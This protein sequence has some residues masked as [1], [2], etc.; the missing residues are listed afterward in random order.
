MYEEQTFDTIISRELERLNN[1]GIDI[2]EGSLIYNAL[3]PSTWELQ[4]I[5]IALDFILTCLYADTANRPYLIR[6]AAERGIIPYPATAAI[7]QGEFNCNIPLGS[8]FSLDDTNWI[9]IE[10]INNTI[11][12]MRCEQLGIIG[13]KKTGELKALEYIENLEYA[14]ITDL[15]IP[16]EEE[17]ETEHLRKRYF[18][19]LTSQAFGGNIADY[20]AKVNSIVGVGGVKVYPCWDGGGTVKL[21]IINSKYEVSSDALINTVQ[22]IVDPLTNSGKGYGIAPIGHQVTIVSVTAQPIDLQIQL[23]Y[24]SGYDFNMVQ[25]SI[26]QIIDAYFLSLNKTW[27]DNDYLVIRKSQIESRILDIHGVLDIIEIK[28]NNRSENLVLDSDTIAVRGEV[29]EG[30]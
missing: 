9:V 17:E 10:E 21:T 26:I 22:D 28:I 19:N 18:D 8:R 25:A 12:K 24:Q 16:A 20:K 6:R 4:D 7:V 13:N 14:R 11:Y 5:Y 29:N 15:L 2:S 3:S 1:Q 23:I 30:C 27:A